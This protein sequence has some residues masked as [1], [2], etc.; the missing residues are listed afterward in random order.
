MMVASLVIF[1]LVVVHEMHIMVRE[2]N[3]L[4]RHIN[5]RI[6]EDVR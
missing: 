4:Q 3:R 2:E 6:R 1:I 5:K